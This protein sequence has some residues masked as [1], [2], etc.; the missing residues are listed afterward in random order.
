MYARSR[1]RIST[2]VKDMTIMMMVMMAVVVVPTRGNVPICVQTSSVSAPMNCGVALR[3]RRMLSSSTICP[4]ANQRP[5][6]R[7]C[8]FFFC[9]SASKHTASCCFS[10][11]EQTRGGERE[12]AAQTYLAV[13]LGRRV[14]H[15]GLR[16]ARGHWRSCVCVCVCAC[17]RACAFVCSYGCL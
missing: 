16:R 5:D 4:T 15:A 12:G 13:V 2:V 11:G 7:R 14:G 6:L 8:I 9:F 17:A 3:L 10:R 1:L